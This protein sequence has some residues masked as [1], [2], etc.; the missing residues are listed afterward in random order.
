MSGILSLRVAHFLWGAD[1]VMPVMPSPSTPSTSVA[2]AGTKP[3]QDDIVEEI[4]G[5]FKGRILVKKILAPVTMNLEKLQDFPED[6]SQKILLEPL[7]ISLGSEFNSRKEVKGHA[8]FY[9]WISAIPEPP[10]LR[11]TPPK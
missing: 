9:P 2:P 4:R 3:V 1:P 8:P 5:K 10:F 11:M 6:P 7:P